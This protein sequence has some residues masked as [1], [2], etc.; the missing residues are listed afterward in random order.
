MSSKLRVA[1]LV[2]GGGTTMAAI[3]HAIDTCRLVGVQ[4]AL[5]VASKPEINAIARAR[6]GGVSDRNVV[7]LR[8]K[9]FDSPDAFG[10]ALLRECKLRDVHLIG[11]YG[12]LPLTPKIVIESYPNMII[13]QHPGPLD[14]GRPD[15]GGKGMYGIRVH[16]ARIRFLRETAAAVQNDL[17]NS[18]C[19]HHFRTLVTCHRVVEEFDKGAI[20]GEEI[21]QADP[22]DTAEVLQA[23]ALPKEHALQIR[24]LQAFA[25]DQVT[26]W[27]QRIRPLVHPDHHAV[28]ER[29]KQE[30]ILR[31]PHG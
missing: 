6:E 7:V 4:A 15:F 19:W 23:R 5:V 26:E 9:E 24:M 1:L 22:D 2:S 13:N 12:W 21:V 29:V 10:E 28:L 18:E 20:L 16:D 14:P 3:L 27:P 31:Y 30:A 8:R 25:N 17:D 11:Q